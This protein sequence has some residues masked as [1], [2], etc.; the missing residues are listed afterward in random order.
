MKAFNYLTLVIFT[1]IFS[2]SLTGQAQ[3]ESMIWLQ[4]SDRVQ[5][6]SGVSGLFL[7]Q[8][9]YF[10]DQTNTYQ[11][12]YWASGAY[13]LKN[14]QIGGG[15]MHFSAHKH[16]TSTYRSV[17][18]SRPFQ[19][20][21]FSGKVARTRWKYH[22][23]AMV[24][25]RLLSKVTGDEVFTQ[26]DFQLRYRLRSNLIFQFARNT[27]LRLS[28]EWLWADA[29]AFVQNRAFAEVTHTIKSL[30]L[31]AGYMNWHVKGI[32]KPWRHVGLLRI[33]HRVSF[34]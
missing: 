27:S 24:E 18:E 7:V 4:V 17:P 1:C 20:L 21:S 3:S 25:E 16:L 5:F 29:L 31:S 10:L 32:E 6:T 12:L 34:R 19:Y 13:H 14:L 9:R 8:K 23:R 33:D 11:D 26:Q 22:I 30:R 15:F 28:N 2:S